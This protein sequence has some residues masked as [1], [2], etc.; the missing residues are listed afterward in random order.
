VLRAAGGDGRIETNSY[1]ATS[2]PLCGNG[3]L[4]PPAQPGAGA[5]ITAPPCAIT[6]RQPDRQALLPCFNELQRL[7]G[8]VELI[9]LPPMRFRTGQETGVTIP[10]PYWKG[11]IPQVV[12]L[13]PTVD[14]VFVTRP[15]VDIEPSTHPARGTGLDRWPA[16]P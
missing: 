3:S 13:N 7:W 8:A 5:A 6:S 4:V 12:C 15:A 16:P 1:D 2:T 10:G 14:V 11:D 9:P